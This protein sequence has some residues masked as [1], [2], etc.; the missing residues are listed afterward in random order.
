MPDFVKSLQGRDLGH[1]RIIAELWGVELEAPDVRRA[2]SRLS[3]YLKNGDLLEQVVKALPGEARGALTDLIKNGGRLSWPVFTRRY[4]A[5]R[6]IGPGKRDRER[7]YAHPVSPAEVLWYRALLARSFFDTPNGPEEFAYI[8]DDLLPL[9]NRLTPVESEISKPRGRLATPGERAYL[10]PARDHLLDHACTLLAALRLG[11]SR[12]EVEALAAAW[13][14]PVEKGGYAATPPFIETLLAAAGLLDS[15]RLPQPEA[16]RAFLEAPRG[17]AMAMLARAWM[18]TPILN[19][20]RLLPFLLIEGEWQNDPLKTRQAVL[21]FLAAVPGAGGSAKRPF[22]SLDAFLAAIRTTHPDFQRPAGDYDSWYIRD[23]ESGDF[24]RGFAHWDAVD[25]ALVRFLLTGPLYWLG[26]LD[27]AAPG[28]E[29]PVTAFRFSAA[30]SALLRGEAPAGFPAE[31]QSLHVRSDARL[32]VPRLSPRAVRYQVARFCAWEGE[33]GE[34][35]QYRITPASLSRA[36]Q[37][38]LTTGHLLAL[39]RRHAK[40]VPPGLVQALERWEAHGS[41]ARLD[42]ITVLRLSS[43][44][45]L[46]ALRS[47]RAGRFLGDLLGPTAVIVKDGAAQ[48][49]LTILAEMGYLGE[50]SFWEDND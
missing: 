19:E 43:P 3:E 38:G 20:L 15:S 49:V 22:W 39:L 17:E 46:Q 37:A 34:A 24:L 10:I 12:E 8:P 13:E 21:E 11:F 18:Q 2:L 14:P 47:S 45:L 30:A 7:P 48:K 9:L 1:L 36:R 6:E 4:G 5:V 31:E 41:E 33:K 27:L 16:A 50:A 26:I 28:P 44:E 25:G 23:A 42:R 40:T 29:G 32:S 35:Y